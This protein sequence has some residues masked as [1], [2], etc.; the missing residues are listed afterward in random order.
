[1]G[2]IKQIMKPNRQKQVYET[3]DAIISRDTHNIIEEHINDG[4]IIERAL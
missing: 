3:F 2:K 4:V 1:M